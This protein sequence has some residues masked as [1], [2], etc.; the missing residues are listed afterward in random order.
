MAYRDAH[1]IRLFRRRYWRALV[2][3]SWHA[4][5]T[6]RVRHRL[7]RW[8][9]ACISNVRG[10]STDM[11]LLGTEWRGRTV[12]VSTSPS[13]TPAASKCGLRLSDSHRP[14]V[15]DRCRAV[16]RDH[17]LRD[18]RTGS[19][20]MHG[21][22]PTSVLWHDLDAAAVVPAGDTVT[23][24][25]RT[26]WSAEAHKL[27]SPSGLVIG[28]LVPV[29]SCSLL[30]LRPRHCNRHGYRRLGNPSGG[31]ALGHPVGD[32]RADGAGAVIGV[33]ANV[34]GGVQRAGPNLRG[35]ESCRDGDTAG[36]PSRNGPD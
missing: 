18:A 32:G 23:A 17:A 33:L 25:G 15:H 27:M 22:Q 6:T 2:H 10:G 9:L 21:S 31:R 8:R 16:A 4:R 12:A 11:F 14:P 3:R 19:A 13:T 5:P 30:R 29:A 20:A 24:E 35:R 28:T 1:G 26:L 36:H 7:T 34:D